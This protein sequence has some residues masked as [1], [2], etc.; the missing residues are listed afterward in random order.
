MGEN[1]LYLNSKMYL[2]DEPE[3]EW[4]KEDT[5]DILD[6]MFPD[7]YDDDNDGGH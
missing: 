7:G 1:E 4:T 3:D 2:N 6:I 5:D